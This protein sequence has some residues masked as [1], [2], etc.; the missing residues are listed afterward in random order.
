MPEPDDDR[1]QDHD[2]P[3]APSIGA[4]T[5]IDHVPPEERLKGHEHS[6]IDAIG[7]D[8][9]RQV[10]GE[11]VGPSRQRVIMTFVIFFAIVAA[12]F[13]GLL[14]LVGQLDQPPDTNT[15]QAPWSAPDVEQAPPTPLQ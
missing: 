6:P 13:V 9:R 3:S 2:L 15:D 4:H 7:L 5:T 10:I 12:V 14:F 1:S 8:K 11:A